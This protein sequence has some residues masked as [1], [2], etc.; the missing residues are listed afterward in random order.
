MKIS[1]YCLTFSTVIDR[2]AYGFHNRIFHNRNHKTE[3]KGEFIL[4]IIWK[5]WSITAEYSLL[6]RLRE[7]Y[8]TVTDQ[9]LQIRRHMAEDYDQYK[10]FLRISQLQ[11]RIVQ[12]WLTNSY[13]TSYDSCY[14]KMY[15]GPLLFTFYCL[16]FLMSQFS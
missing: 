1:R 16:C 8:S 12:F 14:G 11:L 5:K 6:I 7:E 2:C 13:D 3:H 15:A 10:C 4:I 9:F